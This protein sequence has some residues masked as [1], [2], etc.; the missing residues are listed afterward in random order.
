VT[1][2]TETLAPRTARLL[3]RL[4]LKLVEAMLDTRR[5]STPPARPK[6]KAS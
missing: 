2:P 5:R 6:R 4:V 3:K 1:S